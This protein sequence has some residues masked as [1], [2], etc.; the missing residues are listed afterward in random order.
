MT[1]DWQSVVTQFDALPSID[2]NGAALLQRLLVAGGAY[3]SAGRPSV[4]EESAAHSAWRGLPTSQRVNRTEPEFYVAQYYSRAVRDIGMFDVP[5]ELPRD[6][7][8]AVDFWA[9]KDPAV[10][11]R[12]TSY[13]RAKAVGEARLA[14]RASAPTLGRIE[15]Q[16]VSAVT[17]AQAY[18]EAN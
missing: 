10:A 12:I 15:S 1:I 3:E 8:A 14:A 11:R 13:Y 17:A 5:F 18:L 7:L 16:L 6:A 4:L 2:A 9:P